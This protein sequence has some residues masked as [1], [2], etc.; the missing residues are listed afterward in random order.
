MFHNNTVFLKVLFKLLIN[1]TYLIGSLKFSGSA[2]PHVVLTEQATLE[3]IVS[4]A[5]SPVIGEQNT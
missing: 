4:S 2:L 1:K 5:L 3:F